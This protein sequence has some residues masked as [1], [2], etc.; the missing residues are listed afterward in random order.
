MMSSSALSARRGALSQGSPTTRGARNQQRQ[1]RAG[2]R[3]RVVRVEAKDYPKP[4]GISQTENYRVAGALSSRF[5]SDLKVSGEG[6]KKKVA[7]VGAGYPAWRAP[8]IWRRL[9][10]NRSCW[11]R[12][13]CSGVR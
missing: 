5:T 7:I 2:G 10:T 3:A 9:V 8:S 13:T 12:E 6:Q 4:D 1:H 11:R